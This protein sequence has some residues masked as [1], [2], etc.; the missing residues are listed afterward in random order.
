MPSSPAYVAL[1]D[2]V[3]L[4]FRS[5]GYSL[6]PRQP[7]HSILA[8]QHASRVRGRGLNFEELRRYFPGDDIRTIDW[9]VTART[10]KLHVRTYTEE[11]DRPLLLVVDQ[12]ST[13]FFGSRRTMKSV[14]AAEAAALAAWRS[15][16]AGDRVG[17]LVFNGHRIV[18]TEPHRSEPRVLRMLQSIVDLNH[19]LSAQDTAATIGL[20]DVLR[21]AG[22]L[23]KHDFL[24]CLISDLA[25]ADEETVRLMTRINAHNDVLVIFVFD[26]LETNLPNSGRL[27]VARGHERLD[28][29]TSSASL[30]NQFQTDFQDR[31]ARIKQL[32]LQRATPVLPLSTAEDTR[33]QLLDALG[34]AGN[35][36]RPG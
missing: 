33:S 28:V 34:G 22:E 19:E 8:G 20:N 32:S 10:R 7:V 17:G 21:K 16:Q 23:A 30:R 9:H 26:P 31:V 13:M 27:V 29:D 25:G 2:L 11:R 36:R 18:E 4:R 24:V 15:L 1:S 6:L 3:R 35:S 14:V 5:H 12:R